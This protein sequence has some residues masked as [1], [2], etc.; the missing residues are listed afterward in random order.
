MQYLFQIFYRL[1]SGG[2]KLYNQEIRNCIFQ[3]NFNTLL[4]DLARSPD[5]LNAN[6]LTKEKVET[7]RFNNEERILRFFAFYYDLDRYK[8]KLASFL[9]D[10]MRSHKDLAENVKNEYASL[11]SRSLKVAMEIENL[12]TSKNVFEAVLIGIAANISAL[13]TKGADVINK[14]YKDV[15]GDKNFSEEAL[16]EGLGSLEKV[17]NRINAAKIIFARG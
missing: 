11:L 9:N 3:G 16:K 7:S 5:W 15:E 4:K 17:K 10:F 13:E 6:H 8:G 1:N 12:S 14:L 2:N